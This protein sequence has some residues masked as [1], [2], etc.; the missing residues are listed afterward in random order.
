M[1]CQERPRAFL[2]CS[3]STRIPI[4]WCVRGSERTLFPSSLGVLAGAAVLPD[5]GYSLW[6]GDA[7]IAYSH[8]DNCRP[9]A[10]HTG[11]GSVASPSTC[12]D[13][14]YVS[15]HLL[16]VCIFECA[17]LQPFSVSNLGKKKK[18]PHICWVLFDSWSDFCKPCNTAEKWGHAA[19][20]ELSYSF[21]VFSVFLNF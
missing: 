8:S 18:K 11:P 10:V 15:L 12:S 3:G 9:G 19:E 13:A 7:G 4:G 21:S 2:P 17:G 5:L 16:V 1:C 6:H 14:T 20:E